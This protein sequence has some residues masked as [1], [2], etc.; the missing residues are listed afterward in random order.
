MGNHINS[1][2]V[3]TDFCTNLQKYIDLPETWSKT[4]YS[5]IG[6]TP[7][8]YDIYSYEFFQKIFE[9]WSLINYNITT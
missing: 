2:L 7:Q 3:H 5:V 8:K 6:R 4:K 1:Y 9:G